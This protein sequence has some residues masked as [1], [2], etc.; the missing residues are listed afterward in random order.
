MGVEERETGTEARRAVLDREE[1]PL[2]SSAESG[3]EG[4]D[5]DGAMDFVWMTETGLEEEVDTWDALTWDEDRETES[6]LERGPDPE[7]R[8]DPESWLPRCVCSGGGTS[9][10]ARGLGSWRPG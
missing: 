4:G 9:L 2:V 10:G 5:E 6:S 7:D 3:G 8:T 1:V